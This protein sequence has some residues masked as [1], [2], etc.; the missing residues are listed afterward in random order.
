M[1]SGDPGVSSS[2]VCGHPWFGARASRYPVLSQRHPPSGASVSYSGQYSTLWPCQSLLESGYRHTPKSSKSLT[3]FLL[4][5]CVCSAIK[6]QD[7]D[8]LPLAALSF[9]HVNPGEGLEDDE[10]EE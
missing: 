6:V 4:F 2:G 10:L 7:S 8:S 9:L 3:G 5:L 1:A